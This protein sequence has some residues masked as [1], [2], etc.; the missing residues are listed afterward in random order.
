MDVVHVLAMHLAQVGLFLVHEHH[1]VFILGVNEHH[2]ST[3]SNVAHDF[4]QVADVGHLAGAVGGGV[5]GPDLEAGI[6]RFYHLPYLFHYGEGQVALG[7]VEGDVVGVVDVAVTL[8]DSLFLF[9][10][11]E[12]VFAGFPVGEVNEGCGASEQAGATHILDTAG[13]DTLVGEGGN[14]PG[15]VSVGLDAAGHYNLA[16]ER[17]QSSSHPRSGCRAPRPRLSARP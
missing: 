11:L 13:A 7:G 3:P 12:E 5:G 2:A 6:S 14:C 1:D 4:A 10:G 17:R 16:T 9:E 8:E 15:A